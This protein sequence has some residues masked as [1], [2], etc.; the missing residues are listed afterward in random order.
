MFWGVALL[1]AF[2]DAV[3]HSW[4]Q[5]LPES[6]ATL[7]LLLLPVA[8]SCLMRRDGIHFQFLRYMDPTLASFVGGSVTIRYLPRDI[9]E[10][11][12]FHRSRF[13][14]RAVSPDH[15]GLT[16]FLKDIQ[17]THV[18]RRRALRQEINA[19]TGSVTLDSAVGSKQDLSKLLMLAR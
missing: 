18:A 16:I 15:A 6:L 14:C 11:R 4:S 1:E 10:I 9:A 5:H 17:Q 13:L 12:V 19:K 7:D 8:K 2:R 3:R